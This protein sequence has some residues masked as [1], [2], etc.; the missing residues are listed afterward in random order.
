MARAYQ[1]AHAVENLLAN[2]KSVQEQ[3]NALTQA[4]GSL[5]EKIKNLTTANE[6]LQQKNAELE[7]R[8]R[9]K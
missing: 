5:E 7:L 1:E 6:A 8:V 4:K 9:A 2:M 3:I